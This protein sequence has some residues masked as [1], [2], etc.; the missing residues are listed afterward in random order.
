MSGL[1]G[2]PG[3]CAPKGKDAGTCLADLC[4]P[5][6]L[7]YQSLF[8]KPSFLVTEHSGSGLAVSL[9]LSHLEKVSKSCDPHV[10]AVLTGI[11]SFPRFPSCPCS[12]QVVHRQILAEQ[13]PSL[14]SLN[15]FPFSY[16]MIVTL[17]PCFFPLNSLPQTLMAL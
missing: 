6:H 5:W 7:P 3:A 8:C 13:C 1:G 16:S 17:L 15:S 4:P 11:G 14:F 2:A 10:P 12:L 9:L